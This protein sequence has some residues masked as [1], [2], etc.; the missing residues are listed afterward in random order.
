MT[1]PG[2]CQLGAALGVSILCA[3]SGNVPDASLFINDTAFP[4]HGGAACTSLLY[5]ADTDD[6]LGNLSQVPAAI[7]RIWSTASKQMS[8]TPFDDPYTTAISLPCEDRH[9]SAALDDASCW[10]LPR[11]PS[12]LPV[13]HKL[14][15]KLL[16]TTLHS[17][18]CSLA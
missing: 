17:K 10:L 3:A 5:T 12:I 6:I 15:V 18:C 4:N 9:R 16:L 2:N 1:V 8:N 11:Q 13:A 7:R 14:L